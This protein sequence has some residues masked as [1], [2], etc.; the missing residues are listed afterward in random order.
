MSMSKLLPRLIGV[1]IGGYLLGSVPNGV[2]IGKAYGVDPRT[3]GSQRT[4]A[5]N[6]L[7]IL[8]LGPAAIV[9]ALDAGK[10]AAAVYLARGLFSLGEPELQRHTDWAEA[11]GTL[12]ALVGHN[13]SIFIRFKGGRGVLTGAGAMAMISPAAFL[14]GWVAAV[15]PIALT[16]YVSLGSMLGAAA[17]PAADLL[18]VLR[19]RDTV[20]HFLG[21]AL[22]G[23]YIIYSHKDNIERLLNGTER[24][25]G[26]R[27][28]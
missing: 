21:L 23:G 27:A 17:G 1:G 15:V 11:L 10:G 14:C 22:G 4:G 13:H 25:L 3:I 2:L 5:T 28:A 12:A 16:R 7:R 24:K 19:G 6:V 18:L 26:E 9:A 20:A 8:G